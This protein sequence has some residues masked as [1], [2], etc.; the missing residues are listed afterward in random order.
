[1]RRLSQRSTRDNDVVIDPIAVLRDLGIGG[2]LSVERM[3]GG[4]DMLNWRVATAENV[5]VLRVFRPDQGP[6]ADREAAAIEVAASAVPVPRVLGRG[7][8]EDR[9]VTLLEWCPGR[10]LWQ[11]LASAQPATAEAFGVEFGRIEARIHGLRAPEDW[12]TNTWLRWAA[13]EAISERAGAM[14]ESPALLHLDFHPANVLVQDGHITAVLDWVNA[15]AG[16]ARA[17]VAR[18]YSILVADPSARK[19]DWPSRAFRRGWRSGYAREAGWP[20]GLA[21]FVAWAGA[22]MRRDLAERLSDEER[23]SVDA[24]AD[25]WA[26]RIGARGTGAQ[27]VRGSARHPGHAVRSP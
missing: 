6:A 26:K 8:W 21:P 17:D 22:V 2:N 27:D 1:M 19:E 10:P 23:R 14:Q 15:R 11:E 9:P 7:V 18:T 13:D 12:P 24:W 4:A 16:D 3:T 25:R 5:F 20:A